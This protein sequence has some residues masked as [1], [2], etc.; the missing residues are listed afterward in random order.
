MYICMCTKTMMRCIRYVVYVVH[1]TSRCPGTS[2]AG[3]PPGTCARLRFGARVEGANQ[4]W[5]RFAP[6]K[7]EGALVEPSPH[8]GPPP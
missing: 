6:T 1:D 2:R 5:G 4:H 3:A 8:P 7:L